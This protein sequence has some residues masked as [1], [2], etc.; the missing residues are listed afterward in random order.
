MLAGIAAG[1]LLLAALLLLYRYRRRS[2]KVPATSAA[3]PV[4]SRPQLAS[5]TVDALQQA[6]TSSDANAAA[7]ALLQWATTHWPEGPPTSLGALAQ[8]IGTGGDAV[9]ELDQVLYAADRQTWQGHA[10]WEAF[11][12][13]MDGKTGHARPDSESL[14]PLY[15]DWDR[16][17]G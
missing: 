3:A 15:P 7:K 13:G 2:R 4:I 5:A 16:Q 12:Q 8:R 9:R 11:Q 1:I 10:L 17:Q 6:C 14:S